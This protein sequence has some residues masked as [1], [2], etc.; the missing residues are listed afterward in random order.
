[1]NKIN[2]A[3]KGKAGGHIALALAYL[4][5]GINLVT[6]KDI[7]QSQIFSPAALFYI[8]VAGAALLFW[9]I[10]FFL[11]KEK[12]TKKDMLLILPA[13]ILGLFLNQYLFL[14]GIVM[15]TPFDSGLIICT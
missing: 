14:E 1:M 12:V 13:S 3:L 15:T 9:I 4:I 8:R 5:Y 7:S 11:P 6:T 2:E 10:S